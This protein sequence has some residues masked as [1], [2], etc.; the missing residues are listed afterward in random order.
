M[1]FAVGAQAYQLQ[2]SRELGRDEARNQNIVVRC[3]TPTGGLSNQ[4]CQLRRFARC[5]AAANGTRN[6]NGWLPWHDIRNPGPEFSDWRS[7]A[8]A[9]CRAK[10]LR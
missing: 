6:C 1:F 7:A 8:D 5:K 10:G 3:T 4:T 2:S 9:C